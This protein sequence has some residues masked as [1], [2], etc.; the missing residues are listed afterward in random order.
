M[1]TLVAFVTQL[2]TSKPS[3]GWHMHSNFGEVTQSETFFRV[4]H[5]QWR[6]TM[7][8]IHH[9]RLYDRRGKGI[10]EPSPDEKRGK[11]RRRTARRKI[12]MKPL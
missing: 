6:V 7:S 1:I 4:T 9:D 10:A 3:D 2:L 8:R 5:Q 11:H 12:K